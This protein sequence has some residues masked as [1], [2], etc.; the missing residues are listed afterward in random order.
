MELLDPVLGLRAEPGEL[1]FVQ[2]SLRGIIVFIAALVMVRMGD[3]RFMAKMSAIDAILGFILASVLAR[4][5]NGS[6]AF[7]PTLG[8]GF[9]LVFTHKILLAAAF[10]FERFGN[11]LKGCE[12]LVVKE[13]A[14]QAEALRETH[15]SIKDLL[16]E[17]RQEGKVESPEQVKTAYVERSGKISVVPRKG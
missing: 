10:R 6:A 12:T 16:E 2:I 4:A 15:I 14:V 9:V 11:L 3:R 1:T 7:F 17:L 13:G 8:G 5:V